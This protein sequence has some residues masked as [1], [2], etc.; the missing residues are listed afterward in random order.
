MAQGFILSVL[1]HSI[2]TRLSLRTRIQKLEV[3][4]TWT[5]Q[6]DFCKKTEKVTSPPS[7]TKLL[8][9]CCCVFCADTE[10]WWHRYLFVMATRLW[11]YLLLSATWRNSIVMFDVFSRTKFGLITDKMKLLRLLNR[12]WW[13]KLKL[14]PTIELKWFSISRWQKIRNSTWN[15]SNLAL[16]KEPLFGLVQDNSSKWHSF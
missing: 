15:G 4:Q 12:N 5:W 6:K 9:P 2:C 3:L 14:C 10:F 13:D 16:N 11:A 8:N 1:S 7:K